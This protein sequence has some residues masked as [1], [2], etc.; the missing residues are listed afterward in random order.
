VV[1]HVK[2]LLIAGEDSAEGGQEGETVSK[3]MV[4]ELALP[5]CNIANAMVSPP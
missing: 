3:V 4:E 1:V 5:T 2:P